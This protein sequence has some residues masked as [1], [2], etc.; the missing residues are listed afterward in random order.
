[1]TQ[2]PD[3]TIDDGVIDDGGDGQNN[4]LE[5]NWYDALAGEDDARKEQLSKYDSFES[6][7]EDFNKRGDWRSQI[8]GDDDKFK[9]TLERYATPND[10]GSAHREAVQ[11]IRSGQMRDPLPEDATEEQIK[12]FRRNNNIPLEVDGYL[13]DLPDG[14][15]V[16]EDDKE[17][18]MDFLGSLHSANADPKIAHAAIEWYNDFAERQ[19]D[20]LVELDNEQK[21]EV[22]DALRDPE[23]GWG[24]DFRQNMNLIS[25]AL[26]TF[27]GTEAKDQLLNGRF[28]DGRGFFNDISVLKG[29]AQLARQVNDVAPIIAN[30]PDQMKSLHDEIDK[31]EKYMKEKRSE[32]NKDTKAQERLREL[33]DLR[34]KSEQA[35]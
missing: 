35:A 11:K 19:Q 1:M 32:Y 22:V 28:Q 26:D 31:L 4:A 9:S 3:P 23:T 6:F 10:F 25:S 24:K 14:L 17:L 2:M 7:Y 18:M 8:A 16:G 33:Y 30:D 20:A 34:L 5:G 15:V 12:D 27:F 29:F 13:S 21:Q